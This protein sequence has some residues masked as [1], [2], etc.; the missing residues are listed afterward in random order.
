MRWAAA[1]A[2]IAVFFFG[3]A[4]FRVAGW[5]AVAA[6]KHLWAVGALVLA[7]AMLALLWF[8]GRAI[9]GELDRNRVY[10]V[11]GGAASAFL[12]LLVVIELDASYFPLGAALMILGLS[13]IHHR[14]PLRGLQVLTAIYL[15]IYVILVLA[16]SGNSTLMVDPGGAMAF[17]LSTSVE[18][19]PFILLILPGLLFFAAATLFHRSKAETLAGVLDVA[20]LAV[21]A[22][23]LLHVLVPEFGEEFMMGAYVLAAKILNPELVLAALGIAAGRFLGR[24]ALYIASMVFAGLVALATLAGSV[25]PVYTFWPW[26][27]LPGWGIIN[28]ALLA[29]GTPALILLGIGWF[30]RQD[31]RPA[32]ANYGRVLSVFGVFALFTLMLI[33]IRHAYHPDRLQGPTEEVEFYTYSLGM[34]IFGVAL[35]VIG[36]AIQNRGSRMLSFVFVLGAVLKVFLWDAAGLDG[37]WRVLSFFGMGLSLLAISW[38]YARFVFG[39][40]VGRRAEPPPVPATPAS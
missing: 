32:I 19:S 35:L 40:N 18:D 27:E 12:S 7:A 15:G 3:F 24:Q 23:G 10:A 26:L 33:E 16:A 34:L 25:L 14:A 2:F 20:G 30:L 29:L 21:V 28:I 13:Y 11:L 31:A 1:I 17:M 36:V 22:W 8:F 6:N 37:L 5:E 4:M 38:L 39:I 9:S